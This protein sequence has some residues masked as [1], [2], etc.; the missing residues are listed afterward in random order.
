MRTKPSRISRG[1]EICARCEG[2][3]ELLPLPPGEGWGEGAH[4]IDSGLIVKTQSRNTRR[5]DNST[6]RSPLLGER[7]LTLTLSRR[8]R[9]PQ[10]ARRSPLSELGQCI[11]PR[12]FDP[13][14][15]R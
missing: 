2:I 9:G 14:L 11:L 5:S 13:A 12:V 8:E 15:P 7:T 4:T 3:R 6:R 10:Q 1:N